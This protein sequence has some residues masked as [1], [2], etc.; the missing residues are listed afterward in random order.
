MLR[1]VHNMVHMLVKRVDGTEKG[2]KE[3]QKQASAKTS[4]NK[5]KVIPS[6]VRVS[7]AILVWIATYID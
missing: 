1:E 4:S 3:L 6:I 2:L 7:I 5:K